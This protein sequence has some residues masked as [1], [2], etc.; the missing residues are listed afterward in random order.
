MILPGFTASGT[1]VEDKVRTIT[2]ASLRVDET[3][4]VFDPAF[5]GMVSCISR[6]AIWWGH[7]S[8]SEIIRCQWSR[9]TLILEK[10]KDRQPVEVP[11]QHQ[12]ACI[13]KGDLL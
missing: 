12:M 4:P 2:E 11:L 9:L 13:F 7:C 5:Q 10:K 6:F 1:S 8:K 3:G